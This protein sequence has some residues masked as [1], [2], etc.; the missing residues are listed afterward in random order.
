MKHFYLIPRGFLNSQ[1]I[2]WHKTERTAK[3]NL[4]SISNYLGLYLMSSSTSI[5]LLPLS[6]KY[7]VWHQLV[8]LKNIATFSLNIQCHLVGFSKRGKSA[9]LPTP[10]PLPVLTRQITDWAVSRNST[11]TSSTVICLT[12][13]IHLQSWPDRAHLW[14]CEVS[15]M[16]PEAHIY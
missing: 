6:Y 12:L 14:S 11:Y 2:S 5:T 4:D 9:V 7:Q 10:R 1:N 3:L 8:V 13:H 16:L 15:V